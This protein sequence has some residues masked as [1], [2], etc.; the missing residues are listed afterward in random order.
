MNLEIFNCNLKNNTKSR[1]HLSH[2][3]WFFA[4]LDIS[5]NL[6]DVSKNTLYKNFVVG[7]SL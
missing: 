2:V 5:P 3:E 6:F 7:I 4:F 1:N